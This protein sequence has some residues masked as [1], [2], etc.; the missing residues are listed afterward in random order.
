MTVYDPIFEEYES[1]VRSYPRSFPTTFTK[2]KGSCM[3]DSEGREFIDFFDGAGA[4]N[5]GHNNDYIK[6]RVIDYLREDGILHALDMQTVPKAEFIETFETKVLKPRGLDYKIMFCGPTG[7]NS[8]EAALKLSRKVKSRPTVWAMM[9]CFHGMTLGALSLTSQREDRAGA[10]LPLN[11]VVHIPAPYMF[12]ELDTIKYMETLLSD[13]HSG[14][15]LPAALFL[16]TVQAEGGIH[17]FSEQWLRDVRS[18][19]DRHDILL[20]VDDIQVGCARTGNFFSF[21]RAGIVPDMVCLSKSIGAIGLP[22][23]IVLFKPEYDIWSPGEHNGTFRGLQLAFV[24]AKAGI[25]FMLDNK[26]EQEVKR[27]EKIVSEYLDKYIAPSE[28]IREVRGIGLIW[29]L[30]TGRGET[31]KKLGRYC[32]EHGLIAEKCSR[33][34]GA[35]KLM[36]ALTIPDDLLLKGLETVRAAVESLD[37]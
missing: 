19:C 9:G 10:G 3:Y 13:D 27:K 24:A 35:L 33:D 17:V 20:V 37:N 31:A 29:A 21:E 32:F 15:D 5:Y 25:E 28:H 8:I 23:A 6:D 12:P 36:P 4:L 14:C 30:E 16:E 26:I 2:A 1:V 7:T 22:M 34:G 18:F 11:N